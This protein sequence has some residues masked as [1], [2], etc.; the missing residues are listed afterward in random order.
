M[1]PESR[2]GLIISDNI[3]VYSC[4]EDTKRSYISV[5][6]FQQDVNKNHKSLCKPPKVTNFIQIAISKQG[7][8]K[9]QVKC[10]RSI[11]YNNCGNADVTLSCNEKHVYPSL[12]LYTNI[13]M[14][15]NIMNIL[16]NAVK[17]DKWSYKLTCASLDIIMI[18]AQLSLHGWSTIIYPTY[19]Q[20]IDYKKYKTTHN[21]KNSLVVFG[22]TSL[23]SSHHRAYVALFLRLL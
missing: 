16:R 18:M 11:I 14:I 4:A 12:K 17:I 20:A 21:L 5:N 3:W 22:C 1:P 9:M 6:I 15:L 19:H 7:I 23:H 10:F 2:Q 8:L 13:P